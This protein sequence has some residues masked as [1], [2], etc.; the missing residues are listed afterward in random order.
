MD[1]VQGVVRF[2]TSSY[3]SVDCL[4]ALFNFFSRFSECSAVMQTQ[5]NM[6]EGEIQ[7]EE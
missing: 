7:S 5:E 6:E 4:K 3:N 2:T 1:V